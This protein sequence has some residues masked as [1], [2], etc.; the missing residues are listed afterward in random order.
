[1]LVLLISGTEEV[2]YSQM[3]WNVEQVLEVAAVVAQTAALLATT[4]TQETRV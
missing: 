4:T 1:M 3:N 2:T